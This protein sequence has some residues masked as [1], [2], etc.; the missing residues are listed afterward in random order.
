MPAQ[1]HSVEVTKPTIEI[2][3]QIKLHEKG[4]VI[5]RVGWVLILLVMVAGLLGLFG[6]GVLSKQTAAAGNIKAEYERF[7]RYEAEMKV[8]LEAPNEHIATISLP[9]E[10]LKSFRNVRFEPEPLSNN[11]TANEIIYHFQPASNHIVTLYLTPKGRGSLDG[12]MKVN[13]SNAIPLH[14]FIYP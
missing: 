13:G 8:L 7:M 10:Y 3:E 4:W 14:H 6:E 9:Q 1:K 12:T 2:D 11:S 5:Q